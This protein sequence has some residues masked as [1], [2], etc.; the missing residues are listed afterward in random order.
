MEEEEEMYE[1]PP[2]RVGV[3]EE[4]LLE[5]HRLFFRDVEN[6]R[7]LVLARPHR[8]T[9]PPHHTAMTLHALR[10]RV[11]YHSR[12]TPPPLVLV[13]DASCSFSSPRNFS[14]TCFFAPMSTTP[15]CS[16]I[17]EMIFASCTPHTLTP[18]WFTCSSNGWRI[19]TDRGLSS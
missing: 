13:I 2:E 19:I 12:P 11:L 18:T 10:H 5:D 7:D 6:R 1:D 9:S 17:V 15:Y 14:T 8:T 4:K 3:E 16:R